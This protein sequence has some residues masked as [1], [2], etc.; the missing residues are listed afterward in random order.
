MNA[1][2]KKSPGDRR[3]GIIATATEMFVKNGYA[4]TSMAQLA[5]ACGIQKASFYHHFASK[6]D[7]FIACVTEGYADAVNVLIELRA[8]ASLSDPEKIERAI[9][10]LYETIVVSPTGRLSPLV[11]E[12]SRTM[13]SV[14]KGFHRDYIAHQ[15]SALADL[16]RDGVESGS[17]KAQDFDIF[18]HLV[19]G[20]IVTLSLSREM[21]ADFD[22]L[23]D[24]FPVQKLCEGHLASIMDLLA[25]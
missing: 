4:G 10:S 16:V 21:F 3:G 20:P 8:D 15:R 23:D 14:A 7:L 13:P 18:H 11:A 17:F 25:P 5:K 22:D 6:D 9:R 12:V 1:R 24:H 2:E 19:F